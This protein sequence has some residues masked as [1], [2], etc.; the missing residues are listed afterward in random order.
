[1]TMAKLTVTEESKPTPEEF[2]KMLSGAMGQSNPVDELLELS[3]EL[4]VLEEE[5]GMHSTEFY[6]K[7]KR[8]EM[9][10]DERIMHWAIVYHSFLERKRL[11]ESALIREAV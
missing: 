7:Y 9:G 6:E 1:M 11:V 10:D 8:G 4:R 2:Q 5:F 3:H